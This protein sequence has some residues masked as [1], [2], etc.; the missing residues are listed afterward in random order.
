MAVLDALYRRTK[1]VWAFNEK[2]NGRWAGYLWTL[3]MY[4]Y[5][6]LYIPAACR[7]TTSSLRVAGEVWDCRWKHILGQECL[8]DILRKDI[9]GRIYGTK[10]GLVKGV[11]SL[12]NT[13]GIKK[14]K[15]VLL[16]GALWHNQEN[17]L[18]LSRILSKECQGEKKKK[19]TTLAYKFL[20]R[21]MFQMLN[22]D[23]IKY[24]EM[25]RRILCWKK[26]SVLHGC[27]VYVISESALAVN[28]GLSVWLVFPVSFSVLF[29]FVNL[30]FAW[31]RALSH[32]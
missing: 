24:C 18:D 1:R 3:P 4:L 9:K 11:G 10:C 15:L 6:E 5:L 12:H 21:K 14:E 31:I 19:K 30:G 23:W 26:R 17:G 29:S 25:Y 8:E 2:V 32:L 13:W 27:S 16:G 7:C 28:T 20:S 22:Q